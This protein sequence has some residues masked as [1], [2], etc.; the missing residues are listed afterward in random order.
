[1]QVEHVVLQGDETATVLI[2]RSKSN[3]FGDGR[4][5]YLFPLTTRLLTRW[6]RLANLGTGPLFRGLH[7]NRASDNPLA[8]SSIRRRIKRAPSRAGLD[9]SL[10]KR[11]Y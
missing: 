9:A 5:G 6:L 2:P 3:I 7:R 10:A 4:V 11:C 8:T 1:M